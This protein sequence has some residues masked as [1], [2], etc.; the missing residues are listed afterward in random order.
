MKFN[1]AEIPKLQEKCRA[2]FEE[3]RRNN[4]LPQTELLYSTQFSLVVA[5]VLSA[6]ATDKS[7][8][9]VM[10]IILHR[11]DS[12]QKIVELGEH[13]FAELIKSINIYRNKARR[14]FEMAQIIIDKYNGAVPLDFDTLVKLP[15]IG[16][17]TANVILN[18]LT[19]ARRIAVDTHVLRVSHRLGLSISKTPNALEADLYVVVPEEFW[20][21]ANFWLVLHGRYICLARNPKCDKCVILKYCTVQNKEI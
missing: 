13:A 18:V 16:N 20:E 8:N 2:I 4:P 1:A 17:K 3:F 15:G 21:Y 19:G 10:E 5:V 7:V 11:V 12:P 6:Q 9:K 14:I